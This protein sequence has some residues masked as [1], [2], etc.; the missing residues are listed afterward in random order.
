MTKETYA[1]EIIDSL[2]DSKLATDDEL[3]QI[4]AYLTT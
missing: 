2:R 4:Y 1:S 3:S